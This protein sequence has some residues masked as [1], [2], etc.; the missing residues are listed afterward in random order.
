MK[1]RAKDF[2]SSAEKAAIRQ[3]VE[4]AEDPERAETK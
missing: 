1:I 3:A 4:A 2:F